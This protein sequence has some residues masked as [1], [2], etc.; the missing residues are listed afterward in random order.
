MPDANAF[1]ADFGTRFDAFFEVKEAVFVVG[2][3]FGAARQRP[4]R[5]DQF[6]IV[7]HGGSPSC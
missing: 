4:I 7:L 2:M 3:R 6:D 5:S 1:E